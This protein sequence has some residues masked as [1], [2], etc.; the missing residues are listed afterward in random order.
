MNTRTET[1]ERRGATTT[2]RRDDASARRR[3]RK[4]NLCKKQTFSAFRVFV[5]V[6]FAFRAGGAAGRLPVFASPANHT[7]SS[8]GFYVP[9]TPHS[10][11]PDHPTVD[12]RE[13]RASRARRTS[14]SRKTKKKRKTKKNEKTDRAVRENPTCLPMP[15]SSAPRSA[16]RVRRLAARGHVRRG[17]GGR[18]NKRIP[19]MG[20]EPT[21]LAL[22]K[23][24]S[25][26]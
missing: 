21:T 6:C 16:R 13:N 8:R 2:A 11:P 1:D 17:R 14:R 10:C 15:S 24:R 9:I 7:C 12:G 4:R 26:H 19:L 3:A 18:K 22:G 5:F 23:Q 20:I 25:I